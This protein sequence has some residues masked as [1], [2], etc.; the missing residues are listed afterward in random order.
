MELYSPEIVSFAPTAIVSVIG[1]CLQPNNV[2]TAT[3]ANIRIF[4]SHILINNTD[5]DLTDTVPNS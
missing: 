2:K 5:K 4:I 1:V 3:I